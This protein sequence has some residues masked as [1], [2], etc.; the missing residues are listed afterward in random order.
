MLFGDDSRGSIP[1]LNREYLIQDYLR[2]QPVC[3]KKYKEEVLQLIQHYLPPNPM[4]PNDLSPELNDMSHI[5]LSRSLSSRLTEGFIEYFAAIIL[6]IAKDS[7][8]AEQYRKKQQPSENDSTPLSLPLQSQKSG[9]ENY[10]NSN[11]NYYTDE[12]E[13]MNQTSNSGNPV[14]KNKWQLMEKHCSRNLRDGSCTLVEKIWLIISRTD[15]ECGQLF[16]QAVQNGYD[17]IR[18][19]IAS[20]IVWGALAISSSRQQSTTNNL[21]LNSLPPDTCLPPSRSDIQRT[22][23]ELKYL[24]NEHVPLPINS[25]GEEIDPIISFNTYHE[26]YRFVL[27]SFEIISIIQSEIKR[28]NFHQ[29]V[30]QNISHQFPAAPH[31]TPPLAK[32]SLPIGRLINVH[33]GHNGWPHRDELSQLG[34][35]ISSI[36]FEGI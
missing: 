29:L 30:L 7:S 3:L 18:A 31:S 19:W 9:I 32:C 11:D 2:S 1:R 24:L 5:P 17:G 36:R 16:G 4:D 12:D 28:N 14:K 15:G 21:S 13:E 22:I 10:L 35:S 6:R 27:N 26:N 23:S 25:P 34:E 20:Y 33:C 8:L